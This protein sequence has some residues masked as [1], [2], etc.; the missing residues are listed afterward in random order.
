LLL[1]PLV[2]ST[3]WFCLLFV[4][5]SLFICYYNVLVFIWFNQMKPAMFLISKTYLSE[6]SSLLLIVG[7]I[8]NTYQ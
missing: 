7:L 2:Q 8:T 5:I 6:G 3:L 1:T 4:L